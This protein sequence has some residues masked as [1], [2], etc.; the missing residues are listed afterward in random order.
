MEQLWPTNQEIVGGGYSIFEAE[1]K[2]EALCQSRVAVF[3]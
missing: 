1:G 3:N 2:C